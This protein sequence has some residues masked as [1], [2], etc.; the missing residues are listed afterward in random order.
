MADV[1]A[2]RAALKSRLATMLGNTGQ[3]AAYFQTNPTPP[4]LQVL[5]V[6]ADYDTTFG[7]GGD[8]LIAVIQ[9]LASTAADQAAQEQI[10]KWCATSGNTSVK[11]AIETERPQPVTLGVSGV[12]SC[13][14]TGHDRPTIVQLPGGQETWS[15]EFT[16]EIQL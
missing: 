15:V 16:V 1:A 9:G 11:A 12:S 3:A 10:D 7:R 8:T 13:R 14:V 2:I 5:G 4:T 6:S